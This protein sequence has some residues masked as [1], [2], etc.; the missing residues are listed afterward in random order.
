MKCRLFKKALSLFTPLFLLTACDAELISGEKKDGVIEVEDDNVSYQIIFKNGDT[1]LQ[2]ESIK[3]GTS[4]TAKCNL[5]ASKYKSK[6]KKSEDSIN[7]V[8][9][10][11]NRVRQENDIG[12]IENDVI[13][14]DNI[15]FY[16]VYKKARYEVTWYNGEKQLHY[17]TV[18]ADSQLLYTGEEPTKES[19][20]TK[21]YKFKGWNTVRQENDVG[22][23]IENLYFIDDTDLFAVFEEITIAINVNWY[24]DGNKIDHTIVPVGQ[25]VIYN[26]NQT[27]T[28]KASNY[29]SYSFIGWNTTRQDGDVG[30]IITTDIIAGT[31][32]IDMHAVFSAEEKL[33]RITLKHLN[34]GPVISEKDYRYNEIVEIPSNYIGKI[35]NGIINNASSSYYYNFMG[36]TYNYPTPKIISNINNIRATKDTSIFPYFGQILFGAVKLNSAGTT[37]IQSLINDKIIT[38][39]NSFVKFVYDEDIAASPDPV[40]TMSKQLWM[41]NKYKTLILT[42]INGI[43]GVADEGF[44]HDIES[45]YSTTLTLESLYLGGELTTIGYSAF[46]NNKSLSL[47]EL[48]STL[49]S[50]GD[51]AFFNNSSKQT[52]RYNGTKEQFNKLNP[53]RWSQASK[54][55]C[56]DGSF[57]RWW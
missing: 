16:A 1:V 42:N 46:K 19:T 17:E 39:N 25:K 18:K 24:S 36:W 21:S 22:N 52:V 31:D 38:V 26:S 57:D 12:E 33:Y 8:F 14:Q 54:I 32:D 23:I 43:T 35:G 10:G 53:S 45:L 44:S 27:P 48:P 34:N 47:V 15:V 13:V 30:S 51:E 9:Y 5:V 50:V 41:E 4:A 29:F 11:W 7:Y 55:V 6:L 49:K 2:K 28:K 3:K 20:S 37:G 56:T 40:L